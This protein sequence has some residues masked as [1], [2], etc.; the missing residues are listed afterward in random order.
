[1]VKEIL[2]RLLILDGVIGAMVVGE[3]GDIIESVKSG[4]SGAEA[5]A[6]ALSF[7]MAESKTVAHRFGQGAL[8]IIVIEFNEYILIAGPVTRDAFLAVVAKT[9]SNMGQITLE[10]RKHRESIAAG[11]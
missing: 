6:T 5:L 4:L 8:D 11:I 10:M 9:T 2:N 1:M 7:V 3:R